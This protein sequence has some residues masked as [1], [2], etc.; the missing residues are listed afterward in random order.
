MKYSTQINLL[1]RQK[2]ISLLSLMIA[3]AIG[4]FLSGAAL[5]IYSDS[6]T[7]FNV[8]NIVAEVTENQRFALDDMRRILVMAGRDIRE[9]DDALG[10]PDYYTFP[11]V[12]DSH[13]TAIADGAESTYDGGTDNS[14]IVAIR[15]R[16][17]PSCGSY[18]NV[19]ITGK[20]QTRSNGTSY[21]DDKTCRPT[22]VRFKVVNN[23]LICEMNSY[24]T[25][26]NNTGETTCNDNAPI[27][28]FSTTLI[29][30]VQKLKVL[31][32]IDGS[33]SDG[34]ASQ[35]LTA[36]E[37]GNWQDIVSLRFALMTGSQST[38]PST[39]RKA[40]EEPAYILGLIEDEPD[41]D[42]LY[43]VASATLSLRN[44]NTIVQ[45]Q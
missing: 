21:R 22:T 37:V 36:S 5:K 4:I 19:P 41:T 38:L 9:A 13:S 40:V 33:P 24:Y 6:K 35:Y 45:R 23:D 39:A 43:R 10:D 31:Y 16:A 27:S 26:N 14:D 1:N 29:S 25:R 18:Q 20:L 17:G 3:S 8:R 44:F 42:H 7:T 15:Y 11:P 2:G 34:Y 30:G 32:G 12:E 28:S